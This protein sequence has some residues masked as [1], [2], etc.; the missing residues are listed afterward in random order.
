LR[1]DEHVAKGFAFVVMRGQ[2]SNPK[3]GVHRPVD[4]PLATDGNPEQLSDGTLKTVAAN[5]IRGAKLF[6]AP[7]NLI[8]NICGDT[9]LVLNKALKGGPVAQ[10]DVRKRSAM[11]L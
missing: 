3:V 4:M 7:R 8:H 11:S 10:V 5:E 2:I 9:V 6:G 1:A